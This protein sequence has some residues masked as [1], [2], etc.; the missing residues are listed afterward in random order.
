MQEMSG[1]SISLEEKKVK[2]NE[3]TELTSQLAKHQR[4]RNWWRPAT[5]R[6]VAFAGPFSAP[7]E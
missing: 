2:A 5:D 4:R 1:F 6:V 7:M 3:K